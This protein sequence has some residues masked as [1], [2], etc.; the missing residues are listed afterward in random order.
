MF[1]S[2]APVVAQSAQPPT[3]SIAKLIAKLGSTDFR[4]REQATAELEKLGEPALPILRKAATGDVALEVK[5]RINEVV[6]RIEQAPRIAEEKL[7]QNMDQQRRDI[8]DRLIKILAP[9]KQALSDRQLASA[10]YLVTTGRAPTEAEAAQAEMQLKER[11]YKL[12]PALRLARSLVGSKEYHADLAAANSRVLKLQR[13]LANKVVLLNGAE[14]QKFINEV[15][16]SVDKAAKSDMHF[17]DLAHLLT[18]SRFPEP[19]VANNVTAHLKR[20]ASRSSGTADVV[21]ALVNTNEFLSG[22]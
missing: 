16:A 19:N 5:R 18:L 9:R 11:N 14:S 3:E 6:E 10:I 22:P 2:T 8:K 12:V 1:I 4:T 21:W 13:D 20:S 15:A 17:C 7:W